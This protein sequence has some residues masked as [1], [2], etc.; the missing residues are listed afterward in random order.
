[1][2]NEKKEEIYNTIKNEYYCLLVELET[3]RKL[4]D[5][6][7]GLRSIISDS[8]KKENEKF[9]ELFKQ[10]RK[11]IGLKHELVGYHAHLE[12]KNGSDYIG[13]VID[14][15]DDVLELR[16]NSDGKIISIK[17][18]DVKCYREFLKNKDMNL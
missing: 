16:Q 12:L 10:L 4:L 15:K 7:G 1:M 8:I 11:A 3:A 17:L 18:S 14:E 9:N 13:S 5:S 2:N 6:T